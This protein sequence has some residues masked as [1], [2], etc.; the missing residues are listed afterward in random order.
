MTEIADASTTPQPAAP[1][2]NTLQRIAGVLFAPAETF[3]DIARKPNI[4][5]PLLIIVL[6]GYVSTFFIVQR[7]DWSAVTEAQMDAIKKQNPNMSQEDMDRVT[8]MTSAIGKVVGWISPLMG[9]VW[10]VILAGVLLL[11]HRMMGGEGNFQQAFS[12]TLY[13]WMPLLINGIILTIVIIARGSVDPTQ[14]ATVLKSNPAF[15]VD[16]KEQ[17]VLFSLLS[18]FDIFTIWTIVL[19]IIGFAAV[20]KTSKAKSAAIVI[21]LWVVFILIKVGFAAI[22]AAR[23]KA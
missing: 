5:G 22:G 8:R 16:M 15:L 1:T 11:A 2:K 17:A 13:A 20:A 14:M 3:L 18:T 6:L 23:M 19:L 7:M 9:V 10:Y 4:L 21:S 12:V